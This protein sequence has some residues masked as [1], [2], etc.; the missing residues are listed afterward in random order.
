MSKIKQNAQ[1]AFL[2]PAIGLSM[3]DVIS[4]ALSATLILF[5]LVAGLQL[6]KPPIT[7]AM[8]ILYTLLDFV[9][10]QPRGCTVP[11]LYMQYPDGSF[12][13]DA[14]IIDL[15]RDYEQLTPSSSRLPPR[16]MVYEYV[17][18]KFRRMIVMMNPV[19]GTYNPRVYHIDHDNY[20]QKPEGGKLFLKAFFV[21]EESNPGVYAIK[22]KQE[23][24]NFTTEVPSSK[25]RFYVKELQS[26]I[27]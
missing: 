6:R 26:R 10:D 3:L 16:C 17:E 5:V 2:A 20:L 24:V 1:K 19:T 11:G 14:E 8:G 23:R 22:P 21:Q 9:P 25:F 4:N 7:R 27:E 13:L 15:D 18:N 12:N